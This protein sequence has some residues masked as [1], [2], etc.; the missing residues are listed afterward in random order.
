MSAGYTVPCQTSH[1]SGR[2]VPSNASRWP[3]VLK[4]NLLKKRADCTTTLVLDVDAMQA[5]R[6]RATCGVIDVLAALSPMSLA[7]SVTLRC[8]SSST[9]TRTRA[10]LCSILH[11][12][13]SPSEFNDSSTPGA[14][15][16]VTP[17]LILGAAETRLVHS[18][19]DI[20]SR[21]CRFAASQ[22]S[23]RGWSGNAAHHGTCRRTGQAGSIHASP[24]RTMT[25]SG[26]HSRFGMMP[27]TMPARPDQRSASGANPTVRIQSGRLPI[28]SPQPVPPM[29]SA[30][31]DVATGPGLAASFASV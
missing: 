27:A 12:R 10:Q 17:G 24:M 15:R 1:T 13:V 20:C 3:A 5:D 2:C 4:V 30:L 26:L 6:A 11:C 28:P 16:A 21:R 31:D 8:S 29:P 18:E 7:G 9:A 19:R 14:R 23:R 22:F 25:A